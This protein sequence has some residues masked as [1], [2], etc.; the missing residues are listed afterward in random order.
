[1]GLKRLTLH[2]ALYNFLFLA[3][4]TFLFYNLRAD[5]FFV[6]VMDILSHLPVLGPIIKCLWYETV[7]AVIKYPFRLC[8]DL[9]LNYLRGG[10]L[11]PESLYFYPVALEATPPMS[12]DWGSVVNYCNNLINY[13]MFPNDVRAGYT[14]PQSPDIPPSPYYKVFIGPVIVFV[15]SAVCFY[16]V[17][18]YYSV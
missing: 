1:M 6:G 2:V 8:F 13:S 9:P 18:G 5:L 14:I 4:L 10:L 12:N 17:S 16:L 11:L 7:G 3:P 15:L